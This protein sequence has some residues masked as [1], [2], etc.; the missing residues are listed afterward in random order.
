MEP[1]RIIIEYSPA[2]CIGSGD[3]VKNDPTLFGF[4]D[5]ARKAILK[6]GKPNGNVVIGEVAGSVE[7][8][9]Y[10]VNA[11]ASCPV[12]AFVVRDAQ[13]HAVLVGNKIVQESLQEIHAKY[14]DAK[15]FVLDAKGYF[16][17]R[18]N[19]DKKEIE[20]GFCNAKNNMVLK[21]TGA[22]PIA[23]YHTLAHQPNLSLR[24]EHF[25]YLGRELEK[26]HFCLVKN[27]VYV[28]DDP[29]ENMKPRA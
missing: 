28:Q 9:G 27:L 7:R 14:D 21:V 29:L 24:P 26:A 18:V 17:I 13:T 12:N 19:F 1:K 6:G 25:A 4:N 15:E 20:A 2:T 16:L 10:A 8:A 22:T 5:I 3:C 23:I 11:A